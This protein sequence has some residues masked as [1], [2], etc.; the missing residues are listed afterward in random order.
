MREGLIEPHPTFDADNG[1]TL[2]EDRR[3]SIAA[4][5]ELLERKSLGTTQDLY[6]II[7]KFRHKNPRAS[8]SE[9]AFS[10]TYFLIEIET[11]I[12]VDILE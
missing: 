4:I 1:F 6:D 9:P 11:K 7:T 10:E 8:I 2:S 12:I 3:N 5:V